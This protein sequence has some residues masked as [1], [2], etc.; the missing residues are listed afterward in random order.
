V[1]GSLVPYILKNPEGFPH[2]P[3][4]LARITP[5][6]HSAGDPLCPHGVAKVLA[7]GFQ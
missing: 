2:M 1:S 5:R 7:I 3:E 6:P 4:T